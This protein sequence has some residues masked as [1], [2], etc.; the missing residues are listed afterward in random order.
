M[1][2][3]QKDSE[4]ISLKKIIINY[5]HHWRLFLVICVM[6][7]IPAILY[8]VLCPKTYEVFSLIRLQEDKDFGGS[9]GIGFGDAA[10][11]M[12]SFGI[13]NKVGVS[14]NVD[15]EIATLASNSLLSKVVAAL[16]LDVSYMK[17]YSFEKLYVDNS[18]VKIIPDSVFR[19]NLDENFTFSLT[20]TQTGEGV[21]KVKN[22]GDTFSFLSLPTIVNF[23]KGKVR[24]EPLHWNGEKVKLNVNIA[25]I[26]WVAE[27]LA[28]QISIEEYSKNANTIELS[29]EDHNKQRGKDLLNTLVAKFNQGANN[30]KKQENEK[31]LTF[32][33]GRLND[34]IS[35]LLEK[36]QEI[37]KYKLKNKMT[38]IEYD[39]LFYSEA[40][41]SYREKIIE[42]EAQSQ[43]VNLLEAYV[44]DPKNKYNLIPTVFS[45]GESEKGGAVALYNEALIERERMQK[46]SKELNPLTEVADKQLDKLREGVFASINNARASANLVMSDLKNKERE[47]LNKVEQVPVYERE[48][49]D[50][51]RQQEILQGIYLVLLQK[52]EEIALS[53]GSDRDRG[54]STDPAF[55]KHNPIGPRKLFA[56]IFV[57][58][59]TIIFP[60]IYLACKK[61]FEELW[62]EYKSSRKS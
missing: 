52:K 43:I 13:G 53:M 1:K 41:K 20:L 39:V 28:K 42:L 40:V 32:L 50:L 25:P 24:I 59:S 7:F 8:L 57:V 51:K 61:N 4:V 33:D 58:F 49:V 38:D 14:L 3:F 12:R 37:E 62:T 31:S 26:G 5:M 56:A 29:I 10:G 45:T 2:E 48:F 11:L 21:I 27:D 36:E 23:S 47:I 19:L 44:K 55:V 17:P 35:Q 6:S 18:P 9:G 60:I 46:T 54:Y 22:T 16:G 34:I 15:D 30:I